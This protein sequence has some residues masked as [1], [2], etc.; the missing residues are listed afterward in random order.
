MNHSGIQFKRELNITGIGPICTQKS[1]PGNYGQNSTTS[2]NYQEPFYLEKIAKG[3]Y[4][5]PDD[6]VFNNF[7]NNCKIQ[8][9]K[10][11]SIFYRELNYPQKR[12]DIILNK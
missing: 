3:V 2:V 5:V 9:A 12:P 6:D 1:N 4:W 7:V 10:T 8:Y 11:S